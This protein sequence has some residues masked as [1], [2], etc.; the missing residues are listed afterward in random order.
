VYKSDRQVPFLYAV[1]RRFAI[2]NSRIPKI[3]QTCAGQWRNKALTIWK[4]TEFQNDYI[5]VGGSVH[6]RMFRYLY[7]ERK[8]HFCFPRRTRKQASRSSASSRPPFSVFPQSSLRT[9]PALSLCA[10]IGIPALKFC[11]SKLSVNILT[12]ISLLP[13]LP[14]NWRLSHEFSY[15]PNLHLLLYMN[16]NLSHNFK[17]HRLYFP[18]SLETPP[19]AYP[20]FMSSWNSLT[21][22]K[23]QDLQESSEPISVIFI[24]PYPQAI[25][26]YINNSKHLFLFISDFLASLSVISDPDSSHPWVFRI[27]I[28]LSPLSD[29]SYKVIL[30]WLPSHSGIPGNKTV[31]KSTSQA[32]VLFLPIPIWSSS[33]KVLSRRNGIGFG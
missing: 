25:F 18:V 19:D 1:S 9:S 15:K 6:R 8:W 20:L 2:K 30:I 28:M 21:I 23:R 12:K 14:C 22:Q 31:D 33:Y 32:T 26:C 10:Q 5:S 13:N 11:T 7:A 29:T 4:I 3:I 17:F 27:Y 24:N 16:H